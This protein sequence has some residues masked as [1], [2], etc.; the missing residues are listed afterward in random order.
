MNR[1]VSECVVRSQQTFEGHRQ[2]SAIAALQYGR[3]E[4]VG[5]DGRGGYGSVNT[6]D[7]APPG[8]IFD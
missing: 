7:F 2:Q 6:S 8:P 3:V 1:I 4:G 5:R